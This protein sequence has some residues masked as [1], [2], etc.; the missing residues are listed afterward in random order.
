MTVWTDIGDVGAF[1]ITPAPEIKEHYSS[2]AGVKEVDK[3]AITAKKAEFD[4]SIS[5]WTLENATL[6][7]LGAAGTDTAGDFITILGAS[8]VERQIKF[9]GSND[10]GPRMEII[11]PR[12]FM[13]CKDRIELIGDDWGPLKIS[14][15]IMRADL[16][17]GSFG[18]WR[19]LDTATGAAPLTSPNTL[20]YYIGKGII[21]IAPLA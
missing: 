6:A 2:R 12:V 16:V 9:E 15:Q 11:F 17:S 10:F 20:N 7:V 4:M 1:G 8:S 21:S 18:T 5:E 14:G 13:L 19:N 3:I